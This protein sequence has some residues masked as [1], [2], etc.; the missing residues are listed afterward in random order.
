M[1]VDEIRD[2]VGEGW[3]P[4]VRSVLE[5]LDKAGFTIFQLKEKFGGLR[6]YVDA[7]PDATAAVKAEI[8]ALIHAAENASYKTCDLCGGRGYCQLIRDWW[9]TRCAECAVK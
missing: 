3:I 5:V 7:P 2:C 8:S 9:R 1:T 4:I 6:I